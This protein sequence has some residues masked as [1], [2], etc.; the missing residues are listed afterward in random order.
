MNATLDDFRWLV[1][2][3]AVPRLALAHEENGATLQ[4]V[5]RLRKELSAAQAHLVVEQVDLRRRARIK[6]SIA[7]RM[8]FTSRGLE[9]ATDEHLAQYKAARFPAQAPVLD[10]CCGIGGDL[11]ALAGRGPVAGVDLD[12]ASLILAEAN[13]RICGSLPPAGSTRIAD[14]AEVDVSKAAAWHCDPDRRITGRRTTT[15]EF[16]SPPLAALENLLARQPAAAIKLAPATVVPED[17][18]SRAELQ[19]LG[20]RGECRQQVAWF[21]PLAQHPGLRTATIVEPHGTRTIVGTPFA[22]LPV[23]TACGR[24]LYEPHPAV[25]A[26]TLTAALCREHDLAALSPAIA[27]LTGDTTI[28]DLALDAFEVREVLPFDRKR[29]KAYC[30]EHRLGRLEVKKRG[31]EVD[32]NRLARELASAGD[33]PATILLAPAGGKVVAIIARRLNQPGPNLVPAS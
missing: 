13:L 14:A 30:R 5:T 1:S 9:Q 22:D 12:P 33:E 19:W 2:Q 32:P 6:F 29:L 7:E 23:A 4:L 26:A 25:L 31:V 16:F 27:Y 18:A 10:L 8:F 28:D 3:A 11:V 21:G 24:Y 20:S 17:W 15:L